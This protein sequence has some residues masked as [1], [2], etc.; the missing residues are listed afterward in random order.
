VEK[1]VRDVGRGER[2]GQ[3]STQGNRGQADIRQAEVDD[4]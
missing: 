3:L 1:P 4:D 2:R